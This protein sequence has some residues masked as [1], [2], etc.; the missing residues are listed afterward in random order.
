MAE[1]TIE[2]NSLTVSGERTPAKETGLHTGPVARLLAI[3][4]RA[5]NEYADYKM[6]ECTL[7]KISI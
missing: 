1:N 2:G 3:V 4:S 6:D 7:R 5:A